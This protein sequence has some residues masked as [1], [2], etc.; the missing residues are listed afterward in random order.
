MLKKIVPVRLLKNHFSNQIASLQDNGASKENL[1][2]MLG[3]GR[4]KKGMFLG[5]IHEGELEIGQVSSQ[6]N[7]IAGVDEIIHR[8]IDEFMEAK[9]VFIKRMGK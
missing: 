2:K 3:K 6:I 1:S 9:S 8:L 5:D 7:E 4:A